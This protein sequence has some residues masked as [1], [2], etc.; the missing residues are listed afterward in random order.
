MKQVLGQFSI[1]FVNIYIAVDFGEKTG[2]QCEWYIIN[3]INDFSLGL[4]LQYCFLILLEKI[5][6]HTKIKFKS[7]EYGD[8]NYL[9]AYFLQLFI[10]III[11]AI[12]K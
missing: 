3:G 6:S 7:G 4:L 5:L 8:R 11:V 2:L 9:K 10:W 1:H 12:V